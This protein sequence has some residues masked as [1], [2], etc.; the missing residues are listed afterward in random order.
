MD[1][2]LNAI[3]VRGVLP[4]YQTSKVDRVLTYNLET[5][6]KASSQST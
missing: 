2:V 6:A 5:K 4:V 3:H 1:S